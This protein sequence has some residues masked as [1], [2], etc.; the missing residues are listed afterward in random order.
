MSPP[1]SRRAAVSCLGNGD[2]CLASKK[3]D[4]VTGPMCLYQ[5]HSD[6]NQTR[7]GLKQVE[8]GI[9]GSC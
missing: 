2:P 7:D 5:G 4:M 1:S 9:R 8:N 3:R 6:S